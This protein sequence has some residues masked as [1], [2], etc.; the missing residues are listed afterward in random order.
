MLEGTNL[1]Y[2]LD[3][4]KS[5]LVSKPEDIVSYNPDTIPNKDV[6]L[7]ESRTKIPFPCDCI[8]DKFLGHTFLYQYQQKDTY[9]SIAELTFS[10]LTNEEWMERENVYA[11]NSIPKFVKVN[12]T[13]NCFCGNRKVSKDY[14]LFITYPLRS[15]DSLESIAKDT[16]IEADLLQRYNPGVNFSQG[17][18]IVFIP[19][20]DK[21]GV[22]V[23]FPPSPIKA[24]LAFKHIKE[25][26]IYDDYLFLACS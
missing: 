24:G 9:A 8:N 12:V 13:V 20:K 17:H 7:I 1:T 3:I 4:M 5:N 16:E 23:P 22:Y 19:G 2:I 15:E 18:G 25:L 26:A 21:N 14:G 11:K 6:Y 10:N